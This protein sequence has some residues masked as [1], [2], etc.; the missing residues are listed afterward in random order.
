MKPLTQRWTNTC[1]LSIFW[2]QNK[3]TAPQVQNN[4]YLYAYRKDGEA[5]EVKYFV[6]DD[7]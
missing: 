4:I 7:E 6:S 1:D 2:A 3:E 5:K